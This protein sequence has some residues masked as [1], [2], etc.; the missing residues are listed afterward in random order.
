LS[1]VMIMASSVLPHGFGLPGDWVGFT[2]GV[3]V[4][5]ATVGF[6]ANGVKI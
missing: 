2:W 1:L 3:G 6:P 4:T 5:L